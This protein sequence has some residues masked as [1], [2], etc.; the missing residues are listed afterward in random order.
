M[1]TRVMPN[2][3]IQKLIITEEVMRIKSHFPFENK[4]FGVYVY[5]EGRKK[6]TKLTFVPNVI[7]LIIC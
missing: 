3:E 7:S 4:L 2:G 6:G 1:Y 5:Q